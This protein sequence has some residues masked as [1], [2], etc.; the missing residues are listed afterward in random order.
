MV[1][2]LIYLYARPSVSLTGVYQT[3]LADH[4]LPSLQRLRCLRGIVD[5][6]AMTAYRTALLGAAATA[7]RDGDNNDDDG[8]SS[9]VAKAA[10]AATSWGVR[11]R[12]PPQWEV[13]GLCVHLCMNIRIYR[14]VLIDVCFLSSPLWSVLGCGG[15]ATSATATPPGPASPALMLPEPQSHTTAGEVSPLEACHAR[16]GC[17]VYMTMTYTRICG[18]LLIHCVPFYFLIRIG[19]VGASCVRCAVPRATRYPERASE[20][21]RRCPTIEPL[22]RN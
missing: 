2:N 7:A 4:R 11:S 10:G 16:Q 22:C 5:H 19:C 3:C 6:H 21:S 12:S 15:A 13:G 9:V 18:Y 17:A 14:H 8:R 20:S 1:P